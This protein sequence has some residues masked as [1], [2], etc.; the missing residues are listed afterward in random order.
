M[1]TLGKGGGRPVIPSEQR[2]EVLASLACVD[3]VVPFDEPDPLRLIEC[4]LPDVLAKGGDWSPDRIIGRD[5]VEAH[6]GMVYSIPLVPD[7]STTKIIERIQSAVPQA[8]DQEGHASH[9]GPSSKS[10]TAL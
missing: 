3:F 5:V 10:G 8:R 2:A 7:V 1:H 9:R 6:G 4:L